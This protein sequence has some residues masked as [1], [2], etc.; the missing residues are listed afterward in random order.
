MARVRVLARKTPH[1]FSSMARFHLNE[2][3]VESEL[4]LPCDETCRSEAVESDARHLAVRRA[5]LREL[6]C[7]MRHFKKQLSYDVGDGV[8]V[9]PKVGLQ[10]HVN[11]R[12]DSITIDAREED[13]ALA[14]AWVVGAGMP[15]CTLFHGDLPLHGAGVELGGHFLGI[16]APSGAGKSTLLWSLLQAGALFSNDD[17]IPL[18]FEEAR[19]LALPS[20]SGFPK[21]HAATLKNGGVDQSLCRPAP[22]HVDEFWVEIGAAS[23]L[24][25]PRVLAALVVLQPRFAARFSEDENGVIVARRVPEDAATPLLLRN[26]QGVWLLEKQLDE[27]KLV[28]QCATLGASVPLYVLEYAKNFAVLPLLASALRD[29]V[30]APAESVATFREGQRD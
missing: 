21:L 8:L 24:F 27:R 29:L 25:E 15:I 6:P 9:E 4:P 12:G 18:R 14:A 28:Q 5:S 22:P 17:C 11:A 30:N 1:I 23:R 16:M 10:M 2:F 26:L 7:L 20:V 19:V 3:V 13:A